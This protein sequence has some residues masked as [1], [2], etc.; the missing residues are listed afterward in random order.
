M[1]PNELIRGCWQLSSGHNVEGDCVSNDPI[2]DA[3]DCGFTI[4]DAADVYLGV[5]QKLGDAI[6]YGQER[7]KPIRVHTKFVPDRS[8]LADIDRPY[9]ESIIERTRSRLGLDRIDLVQFHWW[10]FEIE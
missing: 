1:N 9:I 5:E 7:S 10:D 4:F 3:I 8:R 6:R 2:H